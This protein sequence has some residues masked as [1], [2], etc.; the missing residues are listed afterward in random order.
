MM[1]FLAL[2]DPPAFKIIIGRPIW[3]YT[4]LPKYQENLIYDAQ[5]S[6]CQCIGQ[7]HNH[8]ID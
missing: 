5:I 2:L 7:E 4:I 1:H 6:A 3:D 8:Y